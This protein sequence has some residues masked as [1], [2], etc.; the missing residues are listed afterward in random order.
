MEEIIYENKWCKVVATNNYYIMK[1][2]HGKYNDQYFQSFDQLP[3]FVK[4]QNFN[5]V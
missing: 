1:S 2:K 3:A 4:T 5:F